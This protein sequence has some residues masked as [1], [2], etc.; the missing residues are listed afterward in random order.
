MGVATTLRSRHRAHGTWHSALGLSL[1]SQG[2]RL[3]PWPSCTLALCVSTVALALSLL[4]PL[5]SLD[6][7]PFPWRP[8]ST[9]ALCG[10][11]QTDLACL[12]ILPQNERVIKRPL[13]GSFQTGITLLGQTC[14]AL[15]ES[16]GSSGFLS[17]GG[18]KKHQGAN[19]TERNGKHG[20][21]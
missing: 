13:Q 14:P 2:P 1:V 12:C 19:P 5:L 21:W 6:P 16:T 7:S 18:G 17:S 11:S 20:K 9:L 4:S 3:C 15:L 10:D 8:S